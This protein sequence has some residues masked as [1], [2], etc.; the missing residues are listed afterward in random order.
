MRSWIRAF[1]A[2]AAFF[3]FAS[4]AQAAERTVVVVLFDGFSPKL[5]SPSD[6]PNLE[7]IAKE[8][9]W[10]RDLV[11]AFPTISL[12][13]HTTFE[14]G[15]WPEHHGIMS[16]EFYDPKRG[17]FGAEMNKAD[18]DWHTG[19]EAMWE[20][21][22]R[23]GVRAAAYNF[24]GRWS[25]KRG[26]LA[27]YA[28]PIVEWKNTPSD[29]ETL[30][31]ALTLLKDNGPNHARLI[32]LYFRGPD[33]AEHKYGTLSPQAHAEARKADGITGRLMAALAALPKD[34]E[35]TLVIG[36]DHGMMDVG[37]MINVS[38]LIN[39]LEIKGHGA[40]DGASAFLYL[41]KDENED[42]VVKALADYKDMFSVYRKGHYPAYAHLGMTGRVGDLLLVSK[43]PYW[44]AD[45]SAFPGWASMLGIDWIWPVAFTP[46]IGGIKATHGYD[47]AMPEMHG[48]FYAWG[49]GVAKGVHVDRLDMIDVHPT[50]MALLGIQ[51][52]KPVDGK[53]VQGVLAPQ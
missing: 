24:V 10:S 1:S 7:R 52:G 43:P 15:C 5:T 6:T 3:F 16:N 9:A 18:A 14:T 49:A 37:P 47:P 12:I 33:D 40:A 46:F 20:A 17:K 42:R 22:E 30:A 8:G 48:I 34:R 53:V 45:D 27:T 51:P 35:G 2:A 25:S 29:D 19:C 13:N 32:A 41:D 36:T 50:V 23:Q 39:K 31:S 4:L 26:K 28:N 38:R 21:A 44:M 11:P